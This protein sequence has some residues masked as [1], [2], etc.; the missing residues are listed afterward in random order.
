M[1]GLCQPSVL[2]R[3]IAGTERV[4]IR[5]IFPSGIV[6]HLLLKRQPEY[7]ASA[8]PTGSALRFLGRLIKDFAVFQR[9]H[10]LDVFGMCPDQRAR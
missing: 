3:T 7:S 10:Q 2:Q 5:K 4:Q 6:R 8:A 9:S 1:R